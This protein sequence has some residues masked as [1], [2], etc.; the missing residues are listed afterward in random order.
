LNHEIFADGV[1]HIA[2]RN[3]MVRI[4]FGSL[5]ATGTSEDG[6]ATF[7]NHSQ[8]VLSPKAFVETFNI[9]EQMFEQLQEKGVVRKQ[10]R[11]S[12]PGGE[13]EHSI[14]AGKALPRSS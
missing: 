6:S 3:G 8:L 1:T 9:M 14:S 7:F 11:R 12:G 4:E 13:E 5:S 2:L 10:E